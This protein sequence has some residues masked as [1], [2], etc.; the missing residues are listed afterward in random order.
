MFHLKHTISVLIEE[1][2]LGCGPKQ[3]HAK[4]G[5]LDKAM[6]WVHTGV[7]VCVC[8]GVCVCV[9]AGC[10]WGC[11]GVCV[12]VCVCVCVCEHWFDQHLSTWK[13]KV[14]IIIE[15]VPIIIDSTR[16]KGIEQA[17]YPVTQTIQNNDVLEPWI[18]FPWAYITLSLGMRSYLTS[19][20][21]EQSLGL[22]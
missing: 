10:V 1:T 16:N 9:C 19:D 2:I 4:S 8:V 15:I 21:I 22:R 6:T 18:P 11:G 3:Q 20:Y 12:G 13:E 14:W 7:W 5:E 17:C